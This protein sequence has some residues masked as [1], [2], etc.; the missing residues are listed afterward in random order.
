[1]QL[2]QVPYLFIHECG[3]ADTLFVP[4]HPYN[5]N[6]KLVNRG[7]FRDSFWYCDTCKKPLTKPGRGLGFR[8]CGCGGAMRGTTLQDPRV[9]LTK[10]VSLVD[11]EEALGQVSSQKSD[12]SDLFVAA[13]LG[14]ASYTPERFADLLSAPDRQVPRAGEQS[15]L[16]DQLAQQGLTSEQIEGVLSAVATEGSEGTKAWAKL[17]SEAADAIE[18]GGFRT[19]VGT[20]DLVQE[21]AFVRDHPSMQ[22]ESLSSL[23]LADETTDASA[24]GTH[25]Q[26]DLQRAHQLGL[27]DVQVLQAFPLLLA[28][29]GYSR[30][31]G[32]P[33]DGRDAALRPFI[34]NR[35]KIP[36]YM[37]RNT[38]EALVFHLDPYWQAAWL[39]ENGLASPPDSALSNTPA[40][41]AW[42]LGQRGPLLTQREAHFSLEPW[43]LDR[44]ERLPG[45]A[46][47][48]LFGL[49]H[50]MSHMLIQAASAQIGFEADSLGEYLF[51]V[52]GAGA[53]YA[54][55]HQDF[56]LGAI[57]SGFQ[58]QLAAWLTTA[59]D[60]AQRCIHDPVCHDDGSACHACSYLGFSCTSFNRT[61]S[62]AFLT[63]GPVPEAGRSF[64]GYWSTG[65][66]STAESLRAGVTEGDS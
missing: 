62:R 30:F 9:Q 46:A 24:S 50:T 42:L 7:R 29:V 8:R 64:V 55:G 4:K 54:S 13:L 41:R 28:A 40:M 27:E 1:M 3:R 31:F 48:S 19:L 37:V 47:A 60:L 53:I 56:T 65:V 33:A 59:H 16:R 49:V 22:G 2:R 23:A 52:A 63:G 43:E 32:S 66:R 45:A 18:D 26:A 58:T 14:T 6:V 25:R 57:L 34:T 36:I 17:K 21:Y 20:S 12:V 5:H 38:T 11:T 44:G 39:I 61:V 15:S 35:P 51:P 10:T